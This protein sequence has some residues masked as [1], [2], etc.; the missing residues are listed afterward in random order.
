MKNHLKQVEI[1]EKDKVKD[2]VK[3]FKGRFFYAEFTKK[4][5]EHRK[6]ISR[7]GVK[8]F[9]SDNP[10][11]KERP[12]NSSLITVWDTDYRAYRNIPINRLERIHGD[13]VEYEIVYQNTEQ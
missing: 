1:I 11:K 5:G 10:N 9:L 7:T 6:M 3:S 4:N 2:V 8:K 13:N 12:K